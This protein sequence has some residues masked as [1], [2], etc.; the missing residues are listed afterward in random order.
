MVGS[1]LESNHSRLRSRRSPALPL[2][3]VLSAMSFLQVFAASLACRHLALHRHFR[4][5]VG[6]VAEDRRYGQRAA[7]LLEAQQAILAGDIAFDGQ[8]I[9]LL[10]M[11]DI[12]DRDVVMLAPEERHGIEL[13]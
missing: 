9:P 6:N 5:Q 10:G 4:L 11:A 8:L 12:V 1:V 7:A 13:F 2:A 3:P